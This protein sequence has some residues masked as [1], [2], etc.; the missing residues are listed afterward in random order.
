MILALDA[1]FASGDEGEGAKPRAFR[2][3]RSNGKLILV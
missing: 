1:F 2:F 3:Q